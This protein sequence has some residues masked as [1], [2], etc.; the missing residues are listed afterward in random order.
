MSFNSTSYFISIVFLILYLNII[1]KCNVVNDEIIEEEDERFLLSTED[2]LLPGKCQKAWRKDKLVGKCFGFTPYKDYHKGL[3]KHLNV[4]NSEQCR[5]LCCNLK[6]K[7]ISW[8][9]VTSISKQTKTCKLTDKIV[10]LGLEATGTPDW[11]DPNPPGKWNGN[12]LIS[13]TITSDGKKECTWGEELPAQCFGLGNEKK[14]NTE[15]LN[16]LDCAEQCCNDDNCKIWQEMPNRGCYYNNDKEVWCDKDTA[17][18][19]GG[20]K[21]VKGFCDGRENE[22]LN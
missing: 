17:T 9:F 1:I 19:M 22:L 5:A 18:Y 12:K 2:L 13:R 21:C 6:E 10:R 16:T 20:R 14:H 4:E 8:Q 7:C 15:Q 3:V 11:C